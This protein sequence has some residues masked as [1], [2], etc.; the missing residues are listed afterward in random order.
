V[1][2]VAS[3]EADVDDFLAST[4]FKSYQ[5]VPLPH[6][7]RTPGEDLS[8]RAEAILGDRVIGRSVLDIGTNYGFFALEASKR[9]ASRIVAVEADTET[10]SIAASIAALHGSPYEVRHGEV[11]GHVVSEQYDV[12]LCLNVLHHM[13]DPIHSMI[14]M[15]RLCRETMIVEFPTPSDRIFTYQLTSGGRASGAG[16]RWGRAKDRLAAERLARSLRR[17][18]EQQVPLM[19]VG[20]QNYR[21]IFHFSPR[22]FELTFT[23]HLPIFSDVRFESSPS[24][25]RVVAVC[26]RTT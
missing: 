20:E 25:D 14:E 17:L 12:V 22:A 16:G 15:S 11:P 8:H 6:G 2:S 10:Y 26:T 24:G 13:N 1:D 21:S 5:S 9:G 3:S 23:L 18:S 4:T 7:R 19:A